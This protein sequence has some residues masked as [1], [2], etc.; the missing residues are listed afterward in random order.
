MQ[1]GD[2]VRIINLG[3]V[4]S[5]FSDVFESMGFKHKRHNHSSSDQQGQHAVVFGKQLHPGSFSAMLY[6][7]QLK[8]GEQ[9]LIG[10]KGIE[11]ISN[12]VEPVICKTMRKT[13]EV[14]KRLLLIG[15]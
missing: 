4:Y 2:T 12:I 7:I 5:N 14:D 11:P 3:K 8:N 15:M 1:I 6:G 10:E 9:L 13:K